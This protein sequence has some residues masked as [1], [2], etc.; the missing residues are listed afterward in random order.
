MKTILAIVGG[1]VLA[2]ALLGSLGIGHFR[3]SYGIAPV[4]CIKGEA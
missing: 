3:L 4:T 2:L 1:S